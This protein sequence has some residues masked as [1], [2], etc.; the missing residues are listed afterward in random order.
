M[1]GQTV[2]VGTRELQI[3]ESPLRVSYL[4]SSI[5]E[6]FVV[7]SNESRFDIHPT[8]FSRV[9]PHRQGKDSAVPMWSIE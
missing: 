9:F 8:R 2:R 4:A 6:K 7:Q 3:E 1:A 5:H